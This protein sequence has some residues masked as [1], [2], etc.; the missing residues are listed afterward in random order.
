MYFFGF[1]C[2]L[3]IVVVGILKLLSGLADPACCVTVCV[4][5]S[6]RSQAPAWFPAPTLWGPHG[7]L[8]ASCLASCV[9]C[10]VSLLG[11]QQMSG[12]RAGLSS[13]S[14]R[15]SSDSPSTTLPVPWQWP[16]PGRTADPSLCARNA[17]SG[18]VLRV[19]PPPCNPALLSLLVCLLQ[20]SDSHRP[21]WPF[22]QLPWPQP[23]TPPHPTPTPGPRS[24]PLPT[25]C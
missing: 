10:L 18:R 24:F 9:L 4:G 13:L 5:F 12:G 19:P 6:W 20:H 23:A 14:T 16:L 2:T 11:V 25:S 3:N 8:E 1:S 17:D 15:L 7:L 22:S 21:N